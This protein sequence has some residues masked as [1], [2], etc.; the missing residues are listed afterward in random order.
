MNP[1]YVNTSFIINF[2]CI[3]KNLKVD[4]YKGNQNINSEYHLIQKSV[5]LS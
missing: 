1:L 5:F 2:C 4:T 3:L